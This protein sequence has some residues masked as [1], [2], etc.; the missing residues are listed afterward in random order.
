[1]ITIMAS[2]HLADISSPLKK[3]TYLKNFLEY[4]QFLIIKLHLQNIQNLYF[5][6]ILNPFD[7]HYEFVL[8]GYHY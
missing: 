5:F 1:M 7:N 4:D 6:Q 2:V 8:F 3:S